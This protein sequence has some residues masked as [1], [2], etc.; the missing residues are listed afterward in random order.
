VAKSKKPDHEQN[1]ET[2]HDGLAF[3]KS[4][5]KGIYEPDRDQRLWLLDIMGVSKKFVR[6][7]DAIRLKV[8]SFDKIKNARD[9]ELIEIKVTAKKLPKFPEGFFFGMTENEEMLMKVLDPNFHLC[10]VSLHEE[11]GDYKMLTYSGLA[12]LVRNKRIQ[13]QINL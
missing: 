5:E 4:K 1:L 13:Y 12:K 10:L 2:E 6:T 9:F 7:F 11:G 8:S 3:L